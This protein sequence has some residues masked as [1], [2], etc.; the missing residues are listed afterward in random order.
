MSSISRFQPMRNSDTLTFMAE[1]F[2]DDSGGTAKRFRWRILAVGIVGGFGAIYLAGGVLLLLH[3]AY[4]GLTGHQLYSPSPDP[5]SLATSG[6]IAAM[7][8]TGGWLLA[9]A[10]QW[11]RGRWMISLAMI[12][13][14]YAIAS[15]AV[16]FGSIP[17]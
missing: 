1:P 15:L 4:F 14:I 9:A 3:I 2:K 5:R 17:E 7:F 12:A 16:G 11:L 10:R 13:M 6:A 8:A